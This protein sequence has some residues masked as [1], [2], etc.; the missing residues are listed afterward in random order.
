MLRRLP[1][2]GTYPLRREGLDPVPELAAARGREPVTRLTTLLGTTIWLVSGYNEARAVLADSTRFSNDVRPV[3]GTR[4]RSDAESVGGLG[5]TDDPDHAR[6]RG[7]L[8]PQ[9]TKR[10]LTRLQISIDTI[11]AD[12]L[13][14]LSLRGQ[15]GPVD[16]VPHFG[17]AIPFQVIC[18]LLGLPVSDRADF[19]QMGAARFDLTHGGVG[20]FGA[21]TESRTF[22]I[23]AV[24]RQRRNPGDG[25][26][27]ALLSAHGDE[28][29]DVE[30]GGLMD[31]VFLGGFE[32]SASMLS[33]GA[34]V[35]GHHPAVYSQ[36]RA[37][38]PKEV[39]AIVEELLRYLCPVQVAFPR[40]ARQDLDLFGQLI[41]RGDIVVVSLSGANRD[42]RTVSDP[43][44]FAPSNTTLQHLAFGHGL[45]RCIGAELARM[46]LRTALVGL[47]T[48][49]PNLAI[50]R[51][52]EVSFR[53]LSAV[54]GIDALPVT[55]G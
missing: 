42:P 17:F 3:L 46:E 38:S 16:L 22:L 52:N 35:L 33:M 34:L 2:S 47:A 10:R 12:A 30:L 41:G 13:D 51:P 9:F 28:F 18:E 20:A 37:G 26:I 53:E 55:L 50:H 7:L 45:H 49:F 40:F 39:D 48:S 6:L 27:G 1:P 25:L 23:D 11:V 54:Y 21:A 43:E 19:Q 15:D 36:L 31:G 29:D 4:T 24:T 8:T 14:A 5:M 32:T 44:H